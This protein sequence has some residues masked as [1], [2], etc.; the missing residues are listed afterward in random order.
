MTFEEQT[1]E[2]YKKD[3]WEIGRALSEIQSIITKLDTQ[4]MIDAQ[5]MLDA[6]TMIDIS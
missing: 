3:I 4:T 6:Q 5:T 1:E 2:A